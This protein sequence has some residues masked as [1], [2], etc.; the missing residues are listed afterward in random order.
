[1]AIYQGK[2]PQEK[3]TFPIT[4]SQTAGLKLWENH[5]CCLSTLLWQPEQT[6]KGVNQQ[7]HI[8][9]DGRAET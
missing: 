9:S 5:S 2:K 3:P 8:I 7:K 1:M 6:N 4:L